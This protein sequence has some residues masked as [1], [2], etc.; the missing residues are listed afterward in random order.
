IAAAF[1]KAAAAVVRSTPGVAETV[2]AR[3]TSSGREPWPYF[4]FALKDRK[5]VSEYAK[6]VWTGVEELYEKCRAHG[7]KLAEGIELGTRDR[8]QDMWPKMKE[9]PAR[10][11]ADLVHAFSFMYVTQALPLHLSRPLK[12]DQKLHGMFPRQFPSRWDDRS[13][14]VMN[15]N[16]PYADSPLW[17]INSLNMYIRETGDTG[18]LTERVGTVQLTDTRHPERSGI[19]GCPVTYSVV[20]VVFEV[21]ASFARMVRDTPYGMAQILYGD[22]CDPVDMFGTSAVGDATTRGKG[23][24]VQTRLSAHL[25]EC[26]V[27]TVDVLEAPGVAETLE[28]LHLEARVRG[29]KNFANRLRAN[30]VKWAWE[31]GPLAGFIDCI[32]ELKVN[33]SRPDYKRGETGYTLGSMRKRDFDRINRRQLVSQAYGLRMLL[34]DRIW[35]KKPRRRD[36]MVRKILKTTDEL[37]YDEKLGLMMFSAAVANN[38][39]SVDLVGR[40]GIFPS[41]CGENGEYHHCQVMMHRNRLSVPGQAANVWRQF[42]MVMSAMRNDD[43]GGPFESPTNC[44]VADRTDPHFAKGMYFGLSGS[45]DWI[46]EIFQR[47]AGVELALHDRSKPDVSVDPRMPESLGSE[48][49]FRRVVHCTPRKG[50]WRQ[51]P[52]EVIVRRAGVGP[53]MVERIVTIN[54][55]RAAEPEVRDLRKHKS[56]KIEISCVHRR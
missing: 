50:V 1:R 13:K 10:V 20:E 23:R 18:I 16:R 8:A 42:P 3:L 38:Q 4:E 37:F 27:E 5:A 43:I 31:D 41:G 48:L 39:R 34:I 28:A 52:L 35:L 9:D 25:F 7:A 32:H 33:G 17:L 22:W 40:L 53:R 47:T 30:A 45:V 56:V 49:R 44:Y 26:L 14:E 46:V 54:G 24:G 11:R 12:L 15:D 19:V 6:S 2:A 51:V 29:L 55:K 36:E 21:F